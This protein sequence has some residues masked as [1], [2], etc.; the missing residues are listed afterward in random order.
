MSHEIVSPQ[1]REKE[2]EGFRR[3]AT[4]EEQGVAKNSDSRPARQFGPAVEPLIPPAQYN[5]LKAK[6]TGRPVAEWRPR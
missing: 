3:G 1:S 2:T 6:A 4:R 5:A